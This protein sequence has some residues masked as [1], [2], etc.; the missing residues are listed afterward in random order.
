MNRQGTQPR[1][2][3]AETSRTVNIGDLESLETI[4][5]TPLPPW[6]ESESIEITIDLD[7]SRALDEVAEL[8]E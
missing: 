1:F 6:H 8:T 3:L 5:P 4:D 7:G 2:P